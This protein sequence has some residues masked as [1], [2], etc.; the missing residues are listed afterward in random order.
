MNNREEIIRTRLT[1]AL[2]PDSLELV[3]ESHKHA[4]HPGARDGGGH[5]LVTIVSAAFI[6]KTPIQRHRMVHEALAELMEKEIHALSISAKTPDA[7]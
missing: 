3:D 5:F 7:Q 6:G 4:G 1:E 2:H